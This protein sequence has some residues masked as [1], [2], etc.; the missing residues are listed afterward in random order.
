MSHS[1]SYPDFPSDRKDSVAV[2]VGDSSAPSPK[3]GDPSPPPRRNSL[4]PISFSPVPTLYRSPQLQRKKAP[5]SQVTSQGP[6]RPASELNLSSTSRSL[7]PGF[8][9]GSSSTLPT[10]PRSATTF[11]TSNNPSTASPGVG[12]PPPT[13]K[14]GSNFYSPFRQSGVATF[15]TPNSGP[16]TAQP[17]AGNKN[18]GKKSSGS[19]LFSDLLSGFK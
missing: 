5:V 17:A 16:S 12:A 7:S 1:K 10:K 11:T 19:A 9:T 4:P 15:S 6:Q 3:N 18:G 2:D 14:S 8:Q 13:I